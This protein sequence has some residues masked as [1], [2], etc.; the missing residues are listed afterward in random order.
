MRAPARTALIIALLSALP[1]LVRAQNAGASPAPCDS[2]GSCPRQTMGM[3]MPMNMGERMGGM[4][5]NMMMPVDDARLDS[6]VDAMHGA[7]GSKKVPAMEKVID[8]L[9]AQRKIMQQHM[10]HMMQMQMGGAGQ[11]PCAAGPGG[12]SARPPMGDSRPR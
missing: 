12:C 4:G 3:P 10:T 1:V 7:K 2:G 5:M 8:E 9:L 6:L 11:G